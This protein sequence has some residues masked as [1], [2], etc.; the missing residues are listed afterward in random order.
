MKPTRVFVAGHRGL[1]GSA[2]VRE[3]QRRFGG[4]PI[5][6]SHDQLD[7]RDQ[8]ATRNFIQAER[9]DTIL[10]AAAKVGGIQANNTDRWE[11]LYENLLIQNSVIGAA[12]EAATPKLV[13]FGSSCIYPKLAEQPLKEE[14]L[15]TGPLEP[16]NEP[17]AIAK[18]AGLKLVEAANVQYKRQWLSLMPTNLYGPGDNFDLNTS[19]VLPAMLR[20]F[21][22]AKTEQAKGRR[23]RVGLWGSGGVLR[24]FLHVDDLAR[25]TFDLLDRDETGLLN[26]GSGEELSIAELAGKIAS[27]VGYDG[28]IDWDVTKPDGTPRKLLDSTR[29]NATGW[30]P[31]IPLDAGLKAVYDW[32]LREYDRTLVGVA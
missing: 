32:Y 8:A 6:R 3:H 12:L 24:E 4:Q 10:L 18:I 2:L 26:V 28:P 20:K 21:H 11:F 13:F 7:L 30:R 31:R 27:T 15:L 25:A 5:V 14:D 16:T 19:H 17:Y 9:P 23:A 1:V 29:V 22:E